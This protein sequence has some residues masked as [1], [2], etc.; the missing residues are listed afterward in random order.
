MR[1]ETTILRVEGRWDIHVEGYGS[2]EE[3]GAQAWAIGEVLERV[4]ERG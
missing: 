4:G 2:S 1:Q 3:G